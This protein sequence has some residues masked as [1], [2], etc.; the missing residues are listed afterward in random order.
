MRLLDRKDVE[1]RTSLSRSTIYSWIEAGKFPRPIRVG[2]RVAW[3]SADV[4]RWIA[5]KMAESNH[6]PWSGEAA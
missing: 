6:E 2:Y 5:Q 3:V 4:D 1:E